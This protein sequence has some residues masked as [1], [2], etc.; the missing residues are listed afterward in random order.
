MESYIW[1]TLGESDK[2]KRYVLNMD[3]TDTGKTVAA[4]EQDHQ[5]ILTNEKWE[6]K[7]FC[8]LIILTV[9]KQFNV[10]H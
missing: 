1:H 8:S 10:K 5:L 2:E 9:R 7:L 3:S 4:F 6:I